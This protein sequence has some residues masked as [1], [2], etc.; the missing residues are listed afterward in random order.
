MAFG[1]G[2]PELR[3]EGYTELLGDI[4]IFCTGGRVYQLGANVPTTNITVYAQPS[5]PITSRIIGSNGASEAMLIIDEAGSGVTTGATGGYGPQAPQ[6]LCTVAEEQAAGPCAAAVGTDNSGQYEVSVV[7]GTFTP[8]QNVYQGAVGDAG[9]NSVTFY[10]V[11]VLPPATAGVSRIFRITNIRVA[12]PGILTAAS[13]NVNL[14]ISTSP[15]LVLPVPYQTIVGGVAGY[16]MQASVNSAPAGGGNPFLACVQPTSPTLAAQVTFTEGF[17]S[18]F[19]TRVVPGGA[20]YGIPGNSTGNTAW[21]AEGQNLVSPSN[22]NIPGGWYGGFAAGNESGFILPS[23]TFTDTTSNITYTG[24]LADFGTRLKAVFSNI[25]A[26]V[27]VYVSATSTGSNTVPGGTSVT[28]YAVLVASSQSDEANNDGANFTPLTSTI[29]GSDGLTAYPLAADNSGVTAAIWEV[30]NANP[31]AFDVLTFSVYI[32]YGSTLGTIQ[33]SNV[34]LSYAPEPGGGTFSPVN[35]TIALTNPEPRFGIVLAQGGPFATINY[36]ALDASTTPVAFNYSIDGTLPASQ[37]VPVSASPSNLPVTVTP[38]V[39]TPP[40]GKWL[41]ATLSSGTLTVSTNPSGLAAS[42]TAYTG[43]VKLSAPGLS[44]VLVPV[45]LTVNAPPA[46][47]TIDMSHSGNFVAGQ[48]AATYTITVGNGA[49][50]G[51][52][53]GTVK[54]TEYPPTGLTVQSM[55]STSSIWTCAVSGCTTTYS[56]QGS[57]TYP[58]IT[59][60]VSVAANAA[61]QLTNV[62]GVSGGGSSTSPNFGDPTTVTPPTCIVT[63][64]QTA[65]VAD[66]QMLI[67]QALGIVPATYVFTT[68]GTISVADV[69]IVTD[70]AMGHGCQ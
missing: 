62:A 69:Q 54:V 6:S 59:V 32:A 33:P 27:T 26:G 40:G 43:N 4:M 35:A 39:T 63:G 66:V 12:V 53:S 57:G 41:S 65:G 3:P 34:A 7:P 8:A 48:L 14:L 42:A 23:A 20:S 11:P 36:C 21:A 46:A 60:T 64:H 13:A 29:T 9:V 51:P 45:T 50:A 56:I 38:I 28:P 2:T 52:T 25:P 30:V 70:A 5:V 10:N 55:T 58:Q 44:D 15:S 47:L 24:G 16:P 18:S 19:K 61:S 22:Q 17:A 67:S 49:S 37:T 31:N 1:A 68:S